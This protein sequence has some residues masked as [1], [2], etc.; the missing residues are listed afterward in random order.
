MSNKIEKPPTQLGPPDL[1]VLLVV[2]VHF[3]FLSLYPAFSLDKLTR[4]C[5][6]NRIGAGSRTSFGR[7]RSVFE[8]LN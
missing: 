2:W 6:E 7:F 8:N 5:D 1:S 3:Q 4:R